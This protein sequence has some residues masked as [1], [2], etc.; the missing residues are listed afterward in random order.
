MLVKADKWLVL[1]DGTCMN[2]DTGCILWASQNK[3]GQK[4]F[5]LVDDKGK[6]HF[7]L[8][9]DLVHERREVQKIER[10]VAAQRDFEEYGDGILDSV[11]QGTPQIVEDFE[12]AVEVTAE[13]ANKRLK[14]SIVRGKNKEVKMKHKEERDTAYTILDLMKDLDD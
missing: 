11:I 7:Y 14:D 13:E 1:E 10:A 2:T 6:V 3:S 5:K 9:R 12:D 8:Q 4:Y